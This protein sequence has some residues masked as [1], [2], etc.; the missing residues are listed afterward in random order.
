MNTHQLH[1]WV[2]FGFSLSIVGLPAYSQ[3]TRPAAVEAAIVEEKNVTPTIWVPGTVISRQDSN[4]A[5]EVA[6]VLNL[7]LEVG[8]RVN[9]GDILAQVNDRQ[10]QLQLARD[11]ADLSRLKSQLAFAQ[12]QLERTESLSVSNNTAEFRIDELKMERDVLRQEIALA[13]VKIEETHYLLERSKIV[14]PFDGVV[15]ARFHQPGEHIAV[16]EEL[17]RL[18]N[19]T[20]LEISAKAPVEV[21]RYVENGQV[22]TVKAG[23]NM[24]PTVVRSI[25]PV[26]DAQS[27][28]LEVRARLDGDWVV[29]RAVSVSL[30]NGRKKLAVVVP[31]DALVLRDEQVF[32]YR[33]VEGM[34]EKVDV[35]LGIGDDRRIAV[36]GNI[37]AGDLVVVRG[38]ERLADG[39]EVDILNEVAKN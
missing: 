38:A 25:I 30:A 26:G 4:V 35:T 20:N 3:A 23:D 1:F 36:A 24:Q 2:L 29:G 16:G 9:Q 28:M 13:K 15:A 10:L 39:D 18:V 27:R 31:R 34:A 8:D 37:A 7:V 6:G 11:R 21:S 14:A 33:I 32:V 5:S 12:K 17:L 22:A 19:T